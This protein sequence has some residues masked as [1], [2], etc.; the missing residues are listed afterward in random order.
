MA[1]K[2]DDN[3]VVESIKARDFKRYMA[4]VEEYIESTKPVERPTIGRD[5]DKVG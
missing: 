2:P 3:T 4:A 5:K 1:I